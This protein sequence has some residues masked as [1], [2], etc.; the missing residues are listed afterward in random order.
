M[1]K[2]HKLNVSSGDED[3][4]FVAKCGGAQALIFP[5]L[6]IDVRVEGIEGMSESLVI[7]KHD[8]TSVISSWDPREDAEVQASNKTAEAQLSDWAT[9]QA[10]LHI[11]FVGPFPSFSFLGKL[12]VRENR[13]LEVRKQ[14]SSGA[15]FVSTRDGVCK[16]E[17][18]GENVTVQISSDQ[19]TVSI[20]ETEITAAELIHRFRPSSP[21][22]H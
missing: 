13:Y 16:I 21:A 7:T 14:D 20:S 12:A 4:M 9:L 15:Y 3:F 2:I 17:K 10:V 11:L 6:W 18:Q 1:G 19:Y 5:L 8:G 22:V